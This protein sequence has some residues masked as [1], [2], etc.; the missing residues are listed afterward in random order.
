MRQPTDMQK[1]RSNHLTALW[2]RLAAVMSS[3]K[4]CLKSLSHQL[5]EDCCLAVSLAIS[6]PDSSFPLTNDCWF[7]WFPI[8]SS[9]TADGLITAWL[10]QLAVDGEHRGMRAPASSCFLEVHKWHL[11]GHVTLSAIWPW[12]CWL[13][14]IRPFLSN[15]RE[16][17]WMVQK[18]HTVIPCALQFNVPLTYSVR[19]YLCFPSSKPLWAPLSPNRWPFFREDAWCSHWWYSLLWRKA[20]PRYLY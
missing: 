18:R 6:P 15:A 3:Y 9:I 7:C 10:S 13:F 12:L 4:L 17:E 11:S 1:I 14:L 2:E 5:V 8:P 20:Q 19:K 16:S